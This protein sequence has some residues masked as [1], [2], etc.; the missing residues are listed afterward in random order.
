MQWNDNGT[1][2]LATTLNDSPSQS[3][4]DTLYGGDGNENIIGGNGSNLIVGGNGTA[5]L[6][7]GEGHILFNNDLESMA[8][9][10]NPFNG[11][12]NV[13]FAGSGRNFV[14]GGGI[15]GNQI[16][17]NP[18]KDY[19][20]PTVGH[21][22]ITPGRTAHIETPP[23][24]GNSIVSP[25]GGWFVRPSIDEWS[26]TAPAGFSN[27][28]NV[29]HVFARHGATGAPLP[30]LNVSTDEEQQSSD[31]RLAE[32]LGLETT[33]DISASSLARFWGGDNTRDGSADSSGGT[34]QSAGSGSVASVEPSD[35]VGSGHDEGIRFAA[36]YFFVAPAREAVASGI[37][38]VRGGKAAQAVPV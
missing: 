31:D 11:G 3:A 35:G 5:I 27:N 22:D 18:L 30:L 7:G 24:M 17:A 4:A 21:I 16:H 1:R 37:P 13:I 14:I 36:Y 34:T 26:G 33:V 32:V 2:Q 38:A 9:S 12:G 23:F 19:I 10:L 6:I 8:E 28:G 15:H 29:F 25:T 20:L